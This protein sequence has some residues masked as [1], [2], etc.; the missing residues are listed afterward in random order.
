[1]ARVGIVF[2]LLL[3]GLSVIG[4][5]ATVNK[6]PTQFVP[7]MLGI[8]ILFCGVVAL[9]PHRRRLAMQS[10]AATGVLGIVVGFVQAVVI[11]VR[12]SDGEPVGDLGW[13][14]IT[15]M[16]WL[17]ATFSVICVI[18]LLRSRR[19]PVTQVVELA[20][21]PNFERDSPSDPVEHASPRDRS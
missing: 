5:L 15:A 1:M 19:R 10:A 2:G 20:R 12:W 21:H 9:N 17:C 4:M 14:L 13:K 16:T 6:D 11:G 8:P 18:L 3:C 7:L